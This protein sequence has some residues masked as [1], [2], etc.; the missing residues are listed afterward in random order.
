[1][2]VGQDLIDHTVARD[3]GKSR[4]TLR[5]ENDQVSVLRVALIKQLLRRVAGNHDGLDGDLALQLG[6]N[7]RK[8]TRFHFIERT[9]GEELRAFLRA[10]DVLQDEA[11]AML[12]ANS[13]AKAATTV[14]ASCRL[15]AQRMVRVAKLR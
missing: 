15:T 9:A 3:G 7:Q 13:A 12:A 11:R 6:G 2:G 8:H 10:D 4:C 1:M 5:T 14:L